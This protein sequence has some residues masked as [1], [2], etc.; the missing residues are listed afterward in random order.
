MPQ[1]PIT[2]KNSSQV[3]IKDLEIE[4][5]DFFVR[6]MSMLGMP[7]SVGEI[8][9][10]LY[11]SPSALS[12]EHIVKHLG[13]S[14]G[15]ASQ[16]LKTLRSLKAVRTSYVPGDRRDHYL[17][18]TEFR[19]LFSN[20]IKEEIMPHMDSAKERIERM[21]SSLP[22]LS[23]EAE[24]FYKIRIEKLKR[25]TRAGGRLLPALAGLLKF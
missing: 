13:I 24:E 14:I 1:P 19:R 17:A 15:S 25:L 21:E 7:K 2:G 4:S 3:N 11:F 16:G 18:E 12:M 10:L 6:M 9:G 8:Y 20:F 5:I 23:N 22:P